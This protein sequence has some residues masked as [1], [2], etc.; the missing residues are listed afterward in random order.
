MPLNDQQV[1]PS[2]PSTSF[3]ISH[4]RLYLAV[5]ATLRSAGSLLEFCLSI[6]FYLIGSSRNL[7][8]SL[9]WLSL[10]LFPN[11]ISLPLAVNRAQCLQ[12][13]AACRHEL[14]SKIIHPPA[15]LR[16]S[17]FGLDCARDNNAVELTDRLASSSHTGL[18]Q[19]TKWRHSIIIP[20]NWDL[21]SVL[22][23]CDPFHLFA[24]I[25][26]L[27]V[28]FAFCIPTVL[29]W[30]S[31]C[32]SAFLSTD[33][34]KSAARANN[35]PQWQVSATITK[36]PSASMQ[37]EIKSGLLRH[38]A[39]ISHWRNKAPTVLHHIVE[40]R[41]RRSRKPE[42]ELSNLFLQQSPAVFSAP[43]GQQCQRSGCHLLN[44]KKWTSESSVA[45]SCPDPGNE[46]LEVTN[47][48]WVHRY[49][50]WLRAPAE[51]SIVHS[52]EDWNFCAR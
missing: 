12:T 37:S 44:K 2:F 30:A 31:R 1:S 7:S 9:F 18:W 33:D 23:D 22:P 34:A 4:N 13:Y 40:Q 17:S 29:P 26:V 35:A 6:W 52:T 27:Q 51:N 49:T 46:I 45:H 3:L 38:R 32:S 48:E 41:Q 15:T 5:H 24:R 36:Q 42:S 39:H 43:D 28:I 10:D 11:P 21:V 20:L 14:V 47:E 16:C 8:G 19:V 50:F 25:K